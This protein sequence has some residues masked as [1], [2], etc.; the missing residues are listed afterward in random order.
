MMNHELARALQADK[1]REIAR[2][3]RNTSLKWDRVP[4]SRRGEGIRHRLAALRRPVTHASA[5]ACGGAPLAQGT[6]S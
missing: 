1:E 3:L 5:P 4:V 2:N 6:V